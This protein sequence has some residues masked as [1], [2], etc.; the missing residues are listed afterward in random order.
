MMMIAMTLAKIGRRMKNFDMSDPS[1][2]GRATRARVPSI[3][4]LRR[5]P[6]RRRRRRASRPRRP[7]PALAPDGGGAP[8]PRPAA[9]AGALRLR[10][11]RRDRRTRAHLH[12][13]VDD[14]LVAGVQALR[15]DPLIALPRADLDRPDRRLVVRADD[16]HRL[17]GRVRR[18]RRLRHQHAVDLADVEPRLDELAG[19]DAQRRDSGPRRAIA[20]SR[21]CGRRSTP[22]SSACRPPDTSCRPAARCRPSRCRRCWRAAGCSRSR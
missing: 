21:A 3:A 9:A 11:M 22:R 17:A 6:S 12:E 19:Q 5:S 16:H 4:S 8:V 2:S 7:R 13:V 20:R 18:D 14:H 15:D 10:R 1:V